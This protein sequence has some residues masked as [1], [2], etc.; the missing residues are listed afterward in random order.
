MGS[1]QNTTSRLA[2][3]FKKKG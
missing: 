2:F 1:K 3:L